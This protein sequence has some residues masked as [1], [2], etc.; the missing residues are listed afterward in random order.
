MP[1][2]SLGRA[3]MNLRVTSRI[4]SMR[5]AW[6]PPTVKSLVSIEPRNVEH[7]HDVDSACL[8]LREAFAE[9]RTRQS[10]HEESQSEKKKRAQEFPRAGGACFP[11]ARRL[12]VEEKVSAAAGPLFPRK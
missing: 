8:H 1:M 11:S 5:V 3:S 10:D 9:L 12:T 2:R 6:S 7:E 4:A